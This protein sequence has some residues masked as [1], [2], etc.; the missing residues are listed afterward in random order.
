MHCSLLASG[1]FLKVEIKSMT[2]DVWNQG[3]ADLQTLPVS[4]AR[5]GGSGHSGRRPCQTEHARR[6]GLLGSP[7]VSP[8]LCT[9]KPSQESWEVLNPIRVKPA[10]N[11]L[12][13]TAEAMCVCWPLNSVP[14]ETEEKTRSVTSQFQGYSCS[15][16][17]ITAWPCPTLQ[18][19]ISPWFLI[20]P[21]SLV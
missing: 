3:F 18:N 17:T 7:A 2:K 1:I 13:V 9:R 15:S 20:L 5:L 6:V 4:T 16:F 14:K 8:E 21:L 10:R 12:S 11:L 19:A